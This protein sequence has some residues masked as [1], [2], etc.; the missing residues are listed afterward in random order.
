MEKEQQDIFV[1]FVHHV[2]VKTSAIDEKTL[3]LL[4]ALKL[5]QDSLN[6]SI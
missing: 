1:L 3:K 6:P 2:A 5:L 4:Q